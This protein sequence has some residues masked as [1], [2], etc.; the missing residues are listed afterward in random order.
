M[1]KSL[2]IYICIDEI[3]VIL[4]VQ[5]FDTNHITH[6]FITDPWRGLEGVILTNCVD[7]CC[8]ELRSVIVIEN[9]ESEQIITYL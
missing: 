7:G 4:C 6:V 9:N 1:N 5:R 2:H 8:A 3:D